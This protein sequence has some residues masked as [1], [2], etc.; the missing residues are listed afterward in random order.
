MKLRIIVNGL[1]FFLTLLLAGCNGQ[2]ESD[3]PVEK[4]YV[5]SMI[6]ETYELF[7]IND[8]GEYY[9]NV[10]DNV[11]LSSNTKV[12]LEQ[13]VN[14]SSN[15]NCEINSFDNNG[16]VVR[17]RKPIVCDYNYTI[18]SDNN[19]YQLTG[20]LAGYSRVLISKKPNESKLI[21]FGIVAY[22]G[23]KTT[24]N[25]K[26]ELVKVGEDPHVL[27]GYTLSPDIVMTPDSKGTTVVTPSN[28]IEYTPAAGFEGNV[29]LS[30][31]LSDT[32]G[33]LLAGSIIV[34]VTNTASTGIEIDEKIT[35][36]DLV[37][38]STDKEIDI[39]KYVH[40]IDPAT[41]NDFQLIY[42]NAFDATVKLKDPT[43]YQNKAFIF[44]ADKIGSYYVNAVVT[45]HRGGYDVALIKVNVTDSSVTKGWGD[46]PLG[47]LVYS[48]PLTYIDTISMGIDISGSNYDSTV[49]MDIATFNYTQAF[50]Y[51]RTRG[52]L[53]TETELNNLYHKK[54]PAKDPQ[55]W[56]VGHKYWT[57]KEA[58]VF[59]L[60]TGK[61]E[62][63]TTPK[64]YY[65]TCVSKGKFEVTATSPVVVNKPGFVTARLEFAGRPVSGK[66]ITA[67]VLSGKATIRN[68]DIV[69][70]IL[71]RAVF[72]VNDT[73]AE[74]TQIKV[75]Y[76][77]ETRVAKIKFVGDPSTATLYLQKVNDGD[78]TNSAQVEGRLS[79]AYANPVSGEYI[80]FKAEDHVSDVSITHDALTDARGIQNAF[81][82]W[83]GAIPSKDQAVKIKATYGGDTET[84]SVNFAFA[85]P[86]PYNL[87]F[88][89]EDSKAGYALGDHAVGKVKVTDPSTG[90]A[91]AD[92]DVKLSIS[93]V[94]KASSSTCGTSCISLSPSDFE[95]IPD[96]I[97]TTADGTG[98]SEFSIR[99]IGS[100]TTPS[101]LPDADVEITA[102]YATQSISDVVQFTTTSTTSPYNLIR[103]EVWDVDS[104]P[105]TSD[106]F[107][108]LPT[109]M[110]KELIAEAGRVVT[111]I[112]TSL[113]VQQK[114]Y[115]GYH[116]EA[117]A[118]YKTDPLTIKPDTII[119]GLIIG[120][121]YSGPAGGVVSEFSEYTY[122][123][124][125]IPVD[126][127][128]TLMLAACNTEKANLPL[129]VSVSKPYVFSAEMIV[130]CHK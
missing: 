16:F 49:N 28:E 72:E 48:A 70:D 86:S 118:Y 97:K 85:T 34:T 9:V 120:N 82:K 117:L 107:S 32:S 63:S 64:R 62:N 2:N 103:I 41:P 111:G 54:P 47:T 128:H 108:D 83:I 33:D 26:D 22:E 67:S 87:L 7:K 60:N 129:N 24:I 125:G 46:I 19:E 100:S 58:F 10:L 126:G 52:R 102:T 66:H 93:S 92:E 80:N 1:I 69:T 84:T 99:Y 73:A 110:F 17:T 114:H 106:H 20:D 79:D 91:V 11:E 68:D 71:G 119:T 104:N 56:P 101:L 109:I 6:E 65:V 8:E 94:S 59:D 23:Q 122:S 57:D 14:L 89:M 61:K 78:S 113:K 12:K 25:I 50:N 116:Y 40:G 115:S 29:T 98:F 121:N 13:V 18:T 36:P 35:F 44:N 5:S 43:D 76:D 123:K 3:T 81:I 88:V 75:K 31:T 95:L 39:S 37:E 38:I 77:G 15:E 124:G 27:D 55:N 51:C 4:H 105:D 90:N 21:P 74:E 53:P 45:D 112:N 42:V 96:T 127:A 130:S 30:Y